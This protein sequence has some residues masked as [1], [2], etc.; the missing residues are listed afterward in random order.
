M[1]MH[2]CV[3]VCVYIAVCISAVCLSACAFL[4]HPFASSK[5]ATEKSLKTHTRTHCVYTVHTEKRQKK[6][7]KGPF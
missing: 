3:C 7:K 5:C 1:Y 6:K 4:M 2:V